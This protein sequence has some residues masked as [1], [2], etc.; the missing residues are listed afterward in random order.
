M[1]YGSSSL[2]TFNVRDSRMLTGLPIPSSQ[3]PNDIV[4][5]GGG[6]DCPCLC[7]ELGGVEAVV[8]ADRVRVWVSRI[9][10][11]AIELTDVLALL[12][13]GVDSTV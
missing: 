6:E 8:V 3:L 4:I 13:L 12:E 11:G 2:T 5:C 10:N 9:R 1:R 7:S